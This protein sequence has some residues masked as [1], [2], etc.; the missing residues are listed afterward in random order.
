MPSSSFNLINLKKIYDC[1]LNCLVILYFSLC[2][3]KATSRQTLLL[4][5]EGKKHRAKARGFHNARR[6]PNKTEHPA[7]N[8][9]APSENTSNG[10]I[11]G[12]R[13]PEKPKMQEESRT[14]TAQN[15]LETENSNL[16]LKEKRKIDEPENDTLGEL[17]NGEVIQLESE[18]L[19]ERGNQLKK[20]KHELSKEDNFVGL[21]PSSSR[22]AKNKIKWKK[23]IT[24]V[25]ISVCTS[26][27]SN[28]HHNIYC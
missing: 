27:Q 23:L 22:D 16:I 18:Q 9:T 11:F 14:M 10:E 2:N 3:T 7:P 21:E 8:P 17:G 19:E 20:A 13:D 1:H 4:H 6:E 25:L 26:E 15:I 12:S 28:S 5:A 24:S